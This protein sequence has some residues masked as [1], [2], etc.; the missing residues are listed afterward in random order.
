M[1]PYLQMWFPLYTFAL[2]VAVYFSVMSLI[3]SHEKRHP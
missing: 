1:W 2:G 3:M